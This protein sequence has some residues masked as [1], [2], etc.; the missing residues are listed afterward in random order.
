MKT[1][2]TNSGINTNKLTNDS[3]TCKPSKDGSLTCTKNLDSASTY[4]PSSN[5]NSSWQNFTYKPFLSASSASLASFQKIDLSG[6]KA[7]KTDELIREIREGEQKKPSESARITHEICYLNM[8]LNKDMFDGLDFLYGNKSLEELKNIFEQ[9][10]SLVE[11]LKSSTNQQP[12]LTDITSEK[13]LSPPPILEP[14]SQYVP[15]PKLAQPII[16]QQKIVTTTVSTEKEQFNYPPRLKPAGPLPVT[17]MLETSKIEL[18]AQIKKHH[19]DMFD[20]YKKMKSISRFAKDSSIKNTLDDQLH[21]LVDKFAKSNPEYQKMLSNTDFPVLKQELVKIAQNNQKQ[22]NRTGVFFVNELLGI[23]SANANPVVGIAL[24]A[25]EIIALGG[26]T[27]ISAIAA[28]KAIEDY[29]KYQ[30]LEDKFNKPQVLATPI[31]EQTGTKETF[32][33]HSEKYLPLP[34]FSPIQTN[35]TAE[36]FPVHEQVWQDLI[37]YKDYLDT[38]EKINDRYPINGDLAGKKY[39][40]SEELQELY[41]KGVLFKEN[42]YPDFT[43]YADITVEVEGLTGNRKQDAKKANDASGFTETPE[44]KTWHHVEDGKTM[45]LVPE[46]LHYEVKHTGGAALLKNKVK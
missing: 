37:L 21:S 14:E 27:L 35:T 24:V 33:D 3:W 16:K 39:P 46:D 18:D 13:Q 26:T 5:S 8:V 42:G 19:S 7:N 2:Y 32:P 45:Q 9:K 41:P 38:V 11:E 6:T 23:S 36:T 44:G 43:P 40:L 17:E 28:N 22:E 29:S 31:N 10:R 1:N 12:K 30:E 34:G 20:V 4:H 15:P 25:E